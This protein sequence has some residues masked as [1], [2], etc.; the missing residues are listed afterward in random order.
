M[1]KSETDAN[2]YLDWAGSIIRRRNA[3]LI[4]AYFGPVGWR[5][6]ALKRM[7]K[8]PFVVTFLGD[9][10]ASSLKP[11]WNWWIQSGSRKPDWPLK[12]RE[13]F[14]EADLLLA[15]GPFLRQ[16]IIDM[17]CPP[18]KIQ[19]QR[20]AVPVGQMPF[21]CRGPKHEGKVIVIFAGRF[22]EQKGLLYALEA[23]RRLWIEQHGIEFR[24]IGDERL[25]GGEY[26]VRAYS[27]I[28]HHHLEHCVRLL[29]FLNHKDY[30]Q[31]MQ[32]GDIFIHPSVTTADGAGEG[33]APT[34]I[35][36]AQALGMPVVSTYHCDIPNVTVPGHSAIL[37]PERDREALAQAL[38]DLV[39]HPERWEEMGR[40]GR[41]HMERLHDIEREAPALEDRYLHLMNR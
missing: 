13:L 10:V 38:R 17:G 31:A 9:E 36:E 40:A 21:R 26:A 1:L 2:H 18:E 5:L 15:E 12:L 27:Y 29:G 34:T 28:R 30:V 23:V 37:V 8:L 32:E 35:L 25:T 4:H 3:R 16:R 19:I 20:F 14:N 22:C 24:I 33:G 6:L 41:R 39:N 7:L 11:W